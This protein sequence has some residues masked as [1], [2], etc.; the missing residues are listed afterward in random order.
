MAPAAPK[1]TI[2]IAQVAGSGT[3]DDTAMS[4]MMFCWFDGPV[5]VISRRRRW[6]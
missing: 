2:I 5:W 4:S 1:P 3:A 6:C